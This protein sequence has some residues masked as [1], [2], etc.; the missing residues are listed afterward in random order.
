VLQE[1]DRVNRDR[2]NLSQKFKMAEQDVTQLRR[3]LTEEDVDDRVNRD[4]QLELNSFKE[5]NRDA[6]IRLA[7]IER[8]RADAINDLRVL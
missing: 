4:L 5:K 2:S 8:R 6:K 7:D 1:L 3:M